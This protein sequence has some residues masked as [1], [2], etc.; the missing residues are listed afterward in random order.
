M[1]R[2]PGCHYCLT[3]DRVVGPV[4]PKSDLG[5]QVPIR[6][7]DLKQLD[8]PRVELARLVIYTPTF[9]LIDD[10]REVGRIEGYPG[11]DFFWARLE[12]LVRSLPVR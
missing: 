6:M 5:K 12:K 4:Y 7:V 10:S 3:W 9:V 1:Y 11:E 8:Q 2:Q